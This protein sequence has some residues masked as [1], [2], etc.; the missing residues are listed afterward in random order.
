[1]SKIGKLFFYVLLIFLLNL[2]QPVFAANDI[3]NLTTSLKDLTTSFIGHTENDIVEVYDE[4]GKYIFSTC[5]GVSVG[6]RYI[7]EANEEYEVIKVEGKRGIAKFLGKVDLLESIGLAGSVSELPPL[8]QGQKN[9]RKKIA[10]YHTHSAES[11]IPGPA[12]KT[13]GE[14]YDVGAALKQQFEKRGITTIQS[15]RSFLPHDGGAYER[16]RGTAIELLRQGPDAIFDIHRDAIPRAEEYLTNV[17]GKK[18]SKVRLVV[19]R[20]NPNMRP[21]DQMARRLKAIADKKYPGL[22]R[23]IF[24][25]KGKYNQDLSPRA[26]L[27]EFGT[28]VTTKEQA[29]AST[30]M[31]ADSIYTMLYGAGTAG[32]DR[33]MSSAGWKNLLLLIGIT[34]IAVVIYLI[35]NEDG[36]S[37][38]L[39]RLKK[40]SGEE[41]ANVLGRYKRSKQKIKKR[42]KKR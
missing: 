31:I 23:G 28:H 40:F 20:Q 39:E 13:R 18:I 22:I 24:Y 21:N 5:M 2:V 4:K 7:N 26:L 15:K 3:G 37:G 10:I 36:L 25:A 1:M 32:T 35:L 30:A 17:K 33:A 34:V 12:F 19:G 38:I 41:F 6:D 29:E 16:S 8:V 42:R 11:Y 27:L 9:K 14:I